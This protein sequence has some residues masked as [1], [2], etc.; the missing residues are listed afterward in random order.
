MAT[1]DGY[2]TGSGSLAAGD[3]VVVDVSRT[4]YDAATLISSNG[5]STGAVAVECLGVMPVLV[6]PANAM[7]YQGLISSVTSCDAHGREMTSR[8]SAY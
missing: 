5:L 2:K 6:A 8:L 1:L 4:N 3:I 7:F